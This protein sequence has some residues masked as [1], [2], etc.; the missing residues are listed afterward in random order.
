MNL[1]KEIWLSSAGD[2]NPTSRTLTLCRRHGCE[3]LTCRN[4]RKPPNNP[5]R[6]SA[7]SHYCH[8]TDEKTETHSHISREWWGQPL[9]A[10]SL[11]LA[12]VLITIAPPDALLNELDCDP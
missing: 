8:L 6:V 1:K 3:S 9:S 4:S 10:A 5:P 12:P 2:R 11:A 7:L